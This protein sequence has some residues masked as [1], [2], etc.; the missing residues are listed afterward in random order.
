MISDAQMAALPI[1][2]HDWHGD[3]NYTLRPAPP[4]PAATS[5][6]AARPL[7]PPGPQLAA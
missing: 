2:R 4:S 1:T 6:A 3:W 7:R 5:A